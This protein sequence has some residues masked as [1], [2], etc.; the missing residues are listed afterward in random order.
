MAITSGV[1]TYEDVLKGLMAGAKVTMMASELLENGLGRIGEILGEMTRW[2][3]EREYESVAQMQG[4]M[5]QRNVG[6]PAAFERA[7]YMRALQS[8][9]PDPAGQL[10]RELLH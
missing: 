5:S 8:W 2:M 4:S 3:E 7:N 9:R 1:H 10:Y 6:D